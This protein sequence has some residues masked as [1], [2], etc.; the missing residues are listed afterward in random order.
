MNCDFAKLNL[1]VILLSNFRIFIILLIIK[2]DQLAITA[3]SFLIN[4]AVLVIVTFSLPT[5]LIAQQHMIII[6]Y[7]VVLCWMLENH[8]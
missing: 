6:I 8:F 3:F 1:F 7:H 2:N 4:I 5:Y